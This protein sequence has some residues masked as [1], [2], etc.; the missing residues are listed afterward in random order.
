M[1][2]SLTHFQ[3]SVVQGETILLHTDIHVDQHHVE[4]AFISPI[5]VLAL[6]VKNPGQWECD[7]YT[8]VCSSISWITVSVFM[9]APCCFITGAL[10][11]SST[12]ER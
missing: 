7:S 12:S 8:C 2:R 5:C 9:S 11:C 3:G 10:Q 1:L 6:F 4:H